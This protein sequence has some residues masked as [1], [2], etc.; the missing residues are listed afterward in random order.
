VGLSNNPQCDEAAR[1][2]ELGSVGKLL[3]EFVT[4]AAGWLHNQGREVVF[5]GEFPLKPGD[6]RTK[7]RLDW[8]ARTNTVLQPEARRFFNREY[9]QPWQLKL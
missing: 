3:A 9:R 2:K 7:M 6:I 4:K 5:W 1:A 8:D